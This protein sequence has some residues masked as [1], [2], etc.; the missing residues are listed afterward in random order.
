MPYSSFKYD[1][2]NKVEPKELSII[3]QKKDLFNSDDEEQYF[4]IDEEFLEEGADLR[5]VRDQQIKS[6]KPGNKEEI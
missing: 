1:V 5:S 3:V 2:S 4:N 6:F